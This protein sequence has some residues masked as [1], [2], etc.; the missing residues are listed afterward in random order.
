MAKT[1]R[2]FGGPVSKVR[3][4][5]NPRI[6]QLISTAKLFTKLPKAFYRNVTGKDIKDI[7]NN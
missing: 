2:R 4:S 5:T 3:A 1:N 7:L 6:R